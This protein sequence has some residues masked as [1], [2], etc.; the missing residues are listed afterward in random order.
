MLALRAALRLAYM[1]TKMPIWLAPL[2][3][4][5]AALSSHVAS[6]ADIELQL[7]RPGLYNPSLVFYKGRYITMARETSAPTAMVLHGSNV[8]QVQNRV[9]A[10]TSRN[11]TQLHTC[12]LWDPWQ[13]IFDECR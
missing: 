2:L 1:V 6:L 13:G 3:F 10:C 8:I 7:G 4:T 9:H 12:Q 11:L 5:V